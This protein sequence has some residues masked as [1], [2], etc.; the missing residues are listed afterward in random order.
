VTQRAADDFRA[1]ADALKAIERPA[2]A[3]ETRDYVRWTCGRCGAWN[4]SPE[5]MGAKARC[6]VCHEMRGTI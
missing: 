3:V 6:R 1:I 2:P 5:V 4:R